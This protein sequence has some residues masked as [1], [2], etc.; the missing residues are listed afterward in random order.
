MQKNRKFRINMLDIAIIAAVICV[1]AIIVFRAEINELIGTPEIATVQIQLT[2]DEVPAETAKTLK[3][4][5]SAT[6]IYEGE[7]GE[8]PL[9]ISEVRYTSP[10]G[11]GDT[12][13]LE[14]T[15][16]TKGYQRFGTYYTEQGVKLGY[17]SEFAV[18]WESGSLEFAVANCDYKDESIRQ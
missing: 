5:D 9:A 15:V 8:L 11:G 16:E 14:L 17:G 12:V 6:L 13:K 3:S 18:K 4:G 10:A 7:Q 2:A 1:A